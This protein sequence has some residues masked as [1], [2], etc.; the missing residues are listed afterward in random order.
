MH[1]FKNVTKS[2]A[3]LFW[4]VKDLFPLALYAFLR[5]KV[6]FLNKLSLKCNYFSVIGKFED[7]IKTFCSTECI[8]TFFFQNV[9]LFFFLIHSD[10]SKPET[11]NFS[12]PFLVKEKK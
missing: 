2:I 8:S 9:K 4:K 5:Q 11:F 1:A 6:F 12:K 10:N 3:G 7:K